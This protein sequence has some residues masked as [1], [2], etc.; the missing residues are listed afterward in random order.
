MTGDV[1]NIM[2]SNPL[3]H[4]S[5]LTGKKPE[6]WHDSYNLQLTPKRS[7]EFSVESFVH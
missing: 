4:R 1:A 2:V 3:K 5:A 6:I 7:A